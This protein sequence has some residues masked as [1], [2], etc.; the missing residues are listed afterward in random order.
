MSRTV[1]WILGIVIALV[2][3]CA[4]VV[5]GV[6]AFNRLG[7]SALVVGRRAFLPYEGRR[8]IPLLPFQGMPGTRF[9]G[10]FPLR[11]LGGWLFLAALLGLFVLAVIALVALL[12]RPNRAAYQAAPIQPAAPSGQ[13]AP[14]QPAAA[15][16]AIPPVPSGQNCPSC[17]RAVQADWSHCPY[18][19]SPLAGT[20]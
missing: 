6:I 10:Y 17:G 8:V 20:V 19:G 14:D 5:V 4:V 7:F 13:K 3:V 2:V 15:D 16:V 12:R 11:F 18:C 9:D 1:K